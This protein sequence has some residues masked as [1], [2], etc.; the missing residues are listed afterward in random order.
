[1]L[2][3]SKLTDYAV[4]VLTRLAQDGATP[5]GRVQTAP[6]LALAT[7]VAEPTVA[8]V[9]K[10]L[11]QAGLVEGVR[12]ARGGYRLTRPLAAMPLTEVILA[13]DGPIALTACVDGIAGMC[14]AEGV[15]P[16]RGRWDPV[17][18]AIRNAISGITVADLAMPPSR[19]APVPALNPIVAE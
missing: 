3:L 2:R 14:E 8:K 17:N 13:F 19:C 10:I 18:E 9:L 15:C 7:G 12:G 16:V 1:M 6:G 5:G 11:S 4:V